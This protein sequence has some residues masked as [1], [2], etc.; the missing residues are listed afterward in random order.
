MPSENLQLVVHEFSRTCLEPFTAD[1]FRSYLKTKKIRLSKSEAYDILTTLDD[2]FALVDQKFITRA[3]AFTDRWFSFKPTREEVEAGAFVPGHRFMPFLDPTIYPR[4]A[5]IIAGGDTIDSVPVKIST[6]TLMDI[7]AFLGEGYV[8]PYILTDPACDSIA[9]SSV[10]YGLPTNLTVTGFSLESFFQ[11]GFEFGDRIL[12]RITDWAHSIIE[13][14]IVK[15]KKSL[16]MTR[17]DM[18]MEEWY[19]HFEEAFLE[20]F[21]KHGPCRSIETQLSLLF[22]EEQRVLCNENCGSAEEFLMHTS[23][24]GFQ[25]YGIESRIWRK[26]EE[27]P[28]IGNWNREFLTTTPLPQIA[29]LSSDSVITAYIKNSMSKTGKI[30]DAETL[31]RQ[32]FP[33]NLSMNEFEE[34]FIMLHLKKRID[35]VKSSYSRFTDFPLIKLRRSVLFLFNRIINLVCEV[36]KVNCI[37]DFPQQDIIVITQILEHTVNMLDEIEEEPSRAAIDAEDM[38]TSLDGMTDTFEAVEVPVM[39]AVKNVSKKKQ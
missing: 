1:D 28:Y 16:K 7:H 25:T 39:Q 12:C 29:L 31:Y 10:Q 23:Q 27:I 30:E 5:T 9:L 3:G 19:S 14:Y 15:G 20:K 38:M 4:N 34:K 13:A 37:E 2:V 8:I 22:L 33:E 26:N 6:N 18:E 35:I 21:E 24:I 32:I 11:Q 17:E 36:N